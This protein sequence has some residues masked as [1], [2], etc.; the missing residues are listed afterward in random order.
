MDK[1]R[2]CGYELLMWTDKRDK[3]YCSKCQKSFS[4]DEATD[5][6]TF[7]PDLVNAIAAQ[8]AGQ[9]TPL[10]EKTLKERAKPVEQKPP[11]DDTGPDRKVA[12]PVS[13]KE[14]KHKWD[15]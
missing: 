12:G 9:I 6:V 11:H 13:E 3:Y 5:E 1:C 15:Q 8:V 10:I 7:S 14:N 4:V 2:N